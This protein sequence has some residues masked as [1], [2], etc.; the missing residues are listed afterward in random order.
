MANGKNFA[1]HRVL[2]SKLKRERLRAGL[3]LKEL[4]AEAR[5][6]VSR[7]CEAEQGY[8]RLTP[9]QEARRRDAIARATERES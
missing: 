4:A 1:T 8:G 9:D 3:R 2:L 7:L 5:I 6:S